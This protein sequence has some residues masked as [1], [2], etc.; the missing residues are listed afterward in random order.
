MAGVFWVSSLPDFLKT[1][2]LSALE[3]EG[4]APKAE[5]KLEAREREA[6]KKQNSEVNSI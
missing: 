2:Y 4:R 5:S 1:L 6:A 3:E